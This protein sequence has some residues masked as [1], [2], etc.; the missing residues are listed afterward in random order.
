MRIRFVIILFFLSLND[1]VSIAQISFQ[2]FYDGF[3][4]EA[5]SV[6][7]VDSSGY[8]L[9]NGKIIRTDL[10]GDTLWTKAYNFG[11]HVTGGIQTSDGGYVI[12]GYT[13]ISNF[14]SDCF[15]SKMDSSGNLL[16]SKVYGDTNGSTVHSIIQT[17]D[18]GFV[19]AGSYTAGQGF[20]SD[21]YLIR[22]DKF[23]NQLWAKAIGSAGDEIA[24]SVI[25][26][27][28]GG[29]VFGGSASAFGILRDAFYLVKVNGSGHVLWSKIYDGWYGEG[30]SSIRQISS[31]EFIIL[32]YTSAIPTRPFV[33][34]IVLKADSAGN[35]M[36]SK[37]YSED[38]VYLLSIEQTSDDGFIMTGLI[39]AANLQGNNVL[40]IKTDQEGDTIWTRSYGGTGTEIAFSVKQSLDG[41]YI[42][43]AI[44]LSFGN[45]MLLIKT[46]SIGNS[47]CN[48]YPTSIILSDSL[49]TQASVQSLEYSVGT[50]TNFT[51][52][53]VFG[54]TV[55]PLCFTNENIEIPDEEFIKIFPNPGTGYFE[56]ALRNK[57]SSGHLQLFNSI[58][59]LISSSEVMNS[60]FFNID[61]S[62]SHEGIYFV[63]LNCELGLYMKKII[64]EK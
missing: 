53:E 47:Y 63:S 10:N 2:K 43:G 20:D 29:F 40:L 61:L 54:T 26:T 7:L 28:D 49:M 45:G 22:T 17:I 21:A 48:E 24:N 8:L 59:E 52:I 31:G 23:G 27:D 13:I 1:D 32:G 46:D 35:F 64:I 60:D 12:C 36:W 19:L 44:S 41:G 30:I 39:S 18:S 58:G 42:V 50:E 57:I 38:D 25:Q 5:V 55:I 16:W 62:S 9:I 37:Y 6:A 33:A 4:G 34:S 11:T 14:N 3:S 56:I 15:L 51:P